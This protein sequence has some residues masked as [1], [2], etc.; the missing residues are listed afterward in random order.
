MDACEFIDPW[1][2]TET[3][4]PRDC[5]NAFYYCRGGDPFRG[6]SGGITWQY[7]KGT[8]HRPQPQLRHRWAR[9]APLSPIHSTPCKSITA[10]VV[11]FR[12][13]LETSVESL[14][15]HSHRWM[16]LRIL[17]TVESSTSP[18]PAASS[19]SSCEPRHPCMRC[20]Y[21]DISYWHS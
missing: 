11:V 6:L 9:H 16:T 20:L 5:V 7:S 1:T 3:P 19:S 17:F 14:R 10:L 8:L 18:S 13:P 21:V 4:P 2:A 15:V 12:S